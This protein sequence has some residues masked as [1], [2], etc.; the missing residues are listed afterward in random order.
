MDKA[1]FP[2]QDSY[3]VC[4]QWISDLFDEAAGMLPAEQ[5][6]TAYGRATS[7][8]AKALKS[9]LWLYA[10]SPL[11][12]GNS[13]YYANFV[14]KVDGRHLISQTYS[15]AKWGKGGFRSRGGH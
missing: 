9:R 13:E 5:T 2:E 11:F 15:E 7:V 3:D 8:A 4:V 6:S 14:S 1:D 12:N 10:A